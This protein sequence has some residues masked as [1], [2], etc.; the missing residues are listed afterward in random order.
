MSKPVTVV[1]EG[2]QPLGRRNADGVELYALQLTVAAGVSAPYQLLVGDSVPPAALPLVFPGSR[3][4]AQLGDDPN[5]LV[6]DWAAGAA[7]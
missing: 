4:H 5:S 1:L 3:L 7:S 6:V 2:H